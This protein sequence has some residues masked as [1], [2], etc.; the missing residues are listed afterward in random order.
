MTLF[1]RF[2]SR[3]LPE[4]SAIPVIGRPINKTKTMNL[5]CYYKIPKWKRNLWKILFFLS[6]TI[7]VQAQ[8]INPIIIVAADPTGA[9]PARRIELSI[10]SGS[11]FF[12]RPD[13][14]VWS[15]G[16]SASAGGSLADPGGNGIVV[17]TASNVTT[18]RSM[19]ATLP[20]T[21]TNADGTAGN[22]TY[23]CPTCTTNAA[24]LTLNQLVFG[25]G[26][27]AVAVGDLTGDITTSGGKATTLATVNAGS[28]S[29]G[30]A[31]QE[32]TII[33][34]A[35]GLVTSQ[36]PTTVTPAD[37]SIT[38][39]DI[40][41]NN[42]SSTSHGFQPKTPANA[43]VFL[44]GA[45]P[46]AYISVPN[47]GLSNSSIT[48]AG[49]TN[50]VNV[51]GCGPVSLGGTCTLSTPQNINTTSTPQFVRIGLGVAAD[52]TVPVIANSSVNAFYGVSIT[53]TDAT[54]TSASSGYLAVADVASFAFN[55]MGSARVVSRWGV[56][57]GGWIEVA[58]SAGSGMA[59]GTR[60]NSPLILGTNSLAGITINTDQSASVNAIKSVGTKFT[61]TGCSA[62]TTLGGATIGSFASGTTGTCTVVIT[63]NGATGLTATNGWACHA[64]NTTTPGNLIDQ[65]SP[66]STTQATLSGTTVSGDV[67]TFGCEGY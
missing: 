20:V 52:A 22:P 16:I 56:T 61:I 42:A 26:S 21:I 60:T 36:T 18:F 51:S 47:A 30:S 29:C 24:S 23:T 8:W 41:T 7:G 43:N 33:T 48:V 38:F 14:N 19:G 53:N 40:T 50:Q 58:E 27:Q 39:T 66:I 65:K 9:C 54:D 17:R 37:A 12:C 62:G 67:I 35:K 59:V 15:V 31:T 44:N 25:G 2:L 46:P 6:L 10:A 55:A 45:N 63:M 3:Y 28:G 49:T 64:S 1:E 5:P 11:L 13:T 57:L 34:N 32:C 4:S